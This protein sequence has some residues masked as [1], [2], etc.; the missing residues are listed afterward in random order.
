MSIQKPHT[1]LYYSLRQV[2]QMLEVDPE[3]IK[4]WE[5]LFPQVTPVRNRAGNRYFAA[6]DM[7]LLFFI[8]ELLLERKL[9]IDEVRRQLKSHHSD[10]TEKSPAYLR[11]ILAEVKLEIDEIRELLSD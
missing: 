11:R 2:S 6:K 8:R 10:D 3:M 1:K 4:E 9:S 7:T 5:K